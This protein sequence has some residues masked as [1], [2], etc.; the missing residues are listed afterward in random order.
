MITNEE[1]IRL[2]HEMHAKKIQFTVE[3]GWRIDK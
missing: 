3:N 1:L 2:Q